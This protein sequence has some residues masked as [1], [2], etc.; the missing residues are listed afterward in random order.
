ML[1]WCSEWPLT[2]KLRSNNFLVKVAIHV[3]LHPNIF[4]ITL[5]IVGWGSGFRKTGNPRKSCSSGI[6]NPKK[7]RSQNF[8]KSRILKIPIPKIRIPGQFS[9]LIPKILNFREILRIYQYFGNPVWEFPKIL[10]LKSV[11]LQYNTLGH[12]DDGTNESSTKRWDKRIVDQ[13]SDVPST[14]YFF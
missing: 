6:L 9:G 8:R 3:P 13:A 4:L 1:D 5:V 12:L 2:K 14:Y 7:S 10:F 11:N